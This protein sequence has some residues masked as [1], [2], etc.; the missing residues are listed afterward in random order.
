MGMG[1]PVSSD[2]WKAPSDCDALYK[3]FRVSVTQARTPHELQKISLPPYPAN[4]HVSGYTAI[5]CP[6]GRK[7]WNLVSR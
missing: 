1:W 3:R 6:K 5:T 7:D 2:K 4:F